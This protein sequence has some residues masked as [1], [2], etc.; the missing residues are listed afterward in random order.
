MHGFWRFHR[1]EPHPA[2]SN[3][4]RRHPPPI[5]R[6]SSNYEQSLQKQ[7]LGNMSSNLSWLARRHRSRQ[8]PRFLPSRSKLRNHSRSLPVQPRPNRFTSPELVSASW[9]VISLSGKQFGL[10]SMTSVRYFCAH[11]R[12]CFPC[13]IHTRLL[14]PHRSLSPSPAPPLSPSRLP[15][16]TSTPSSRVNMTGRQTQVE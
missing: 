15:L 1:A 14:Y 2:R 8:L 6:R 12:P 3:R 5:M 16:S 7:R 13:L 11:C 9:Y 10:S 4:L